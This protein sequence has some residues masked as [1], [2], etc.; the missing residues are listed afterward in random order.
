M[1]WLSRL[2]PVSGLRNQIGL[3]SALMVIT[4]SLVLSY[5]AGE[6]SKQQI[7]QSQ[8]EEF[9]RRAKSILDVM[10]RSMFERSREIQNVAGLDDMRSPKVSI[11][12]KRA[13]LENL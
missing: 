9:A 6:N 3:A 2:S 13:L 12:R 4:L 8:G 5:Y 10:D 1:S 7:E 11:E